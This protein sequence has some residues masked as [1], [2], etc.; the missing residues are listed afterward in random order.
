[1]LYAEL[2]WASFRPDSPTV[3]GAVLSLFLH[4]SW[5]HLFG[6]AI[7]LLVFGRQLEG[8]LGF[9]MVASVFVLGGVVGCFTQAFATAGDAWNRSS[10]VVGAS[11]AIAALLGASVLRFH[12]TRIR[13]LYFLFA[14]LGGVTKGGVVYVNTVVAT[15]G[16]FV[17]QVVYGLVAWGNGGAG[18]A[19]MAHVGGFVSG[20]LLGL[21]LGLPAK[22]K[23]E[24]HLERGARYF[25]AG[26]WYAAAGEFTEHLRVTT[27]S[28]QARALRARCYVLLGRAAEATADYQAAL[29]LARRRDDVAA[30]A[31]IYREMRRYGIGTNLPGPALL[32]LAFEFQKAGKYKAAIE[33][34]WQF[35]TSSEGNDRA[36]L[37]AIRRA[38]LL[39][40]RIGDVEAA[41]AAYRTL[42]EQ[43]VS[44]EW[45]E[46]AEARLQSMHALTGFGSS[47]TPT[48]DSPIP[49][50]ASCSRRGTASS[51]RRWPLSR[52]R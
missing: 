46:V 28:E 12:H 45:R 7:Y 25:E 40:E 3:S 41:K 14:F 10:P 42:L 17:F 38:E 21:V 26:N 9:L 2:I 52:S 36:E 20:V 8:R 30:V 39:W 19:Y 48:S 11:G 13:V 49:A 47:T 51:R 16:W 22:A 15:V 32:R 33:A 5:A 35:E 31:D 43:G 37:A 1:M 44:G 18:T 4:G 24:I 29:Q 6:N 34:Y 50:P 23:R 27:E